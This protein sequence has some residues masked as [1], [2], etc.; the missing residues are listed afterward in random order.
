MSAPLRVP[1]GYEAAQAGVVRFFGLTPALPCLESIVTSGATL[2][3]W[4]AGN[5]DRRSLPGRGPVYSVPSPAPG[6]APSPRWVVRHY[7]RGG[8]LANWMGDRY[9]PLGDPRPVREA[10][11]SLEAR[12]RGVPTPRVVGGAAY[13]AG[14]LYRA[15][16]ITEEIPDSADL[17]T[18]L[19]G[20]P[21]FAE[22]EAGLPPRRR[23]MVDPEEVLYQAGRLVGSL[24]LAGIFHPD[25]HAGNVVL[26]SRPEGPRAHLVDLD[27][28]RV[29][30]LVVP[31]AAARMRRRLERSLRKLERRRGVSLPSDAWSRLREGFA[32]P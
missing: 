3:G 17:A 29:R 28:C 15:D 26:E 16:L 14:R 8:W 25:L 24:E 4:A 19:L 12:C 7:H 32:S 10:W 18:L 2:H 20:S 21:L 30:T 5:P 22:A 27:R 1:E 9:A 11:A 31:A 13:E 6:P 23:G